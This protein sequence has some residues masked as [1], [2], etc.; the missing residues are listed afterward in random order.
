M[1][2][3]TTPMQPPFNPDPL[4]LKDY[5]HAVDAEQV[6]ACLGAIWVTSGEDNAGSGP[7]RPPRN[8]RLTPLDVQ[9]W[10]G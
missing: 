9:M 4:L 3:P 6:R 2:R 7:R 5:K 8:G 10:P 1:P